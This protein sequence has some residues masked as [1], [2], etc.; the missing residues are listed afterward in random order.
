MA[1]LVVV[2][3]QPLV[4]QLKVPHSSSRQRWVEPYLFSPIGMSHFERAAGPVHVHP[5]GA[6]RRRRD[7][8][9]GA[10]E[11]MTHVVILRTAAAPLQGRALTRYRQFD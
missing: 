4:G 11:R 1:A 10:D 2:H 6:G 8:R 9:E 5:D 3:E 7:E